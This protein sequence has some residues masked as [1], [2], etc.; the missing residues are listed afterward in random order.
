MKYRMEV[1]RVST[2]QLLIV[3]S[4]P[5]RLP[6]MKVREGAAVVP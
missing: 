6:P 1:D 2:R 4:E 5:P 3:T